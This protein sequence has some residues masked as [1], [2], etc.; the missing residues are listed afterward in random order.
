MRLKY[1][2]LSAALVAVSQVKVV[3]S[4]T[5]L[6]CAQTD[7]PAYTIAGKDSTCQIFIYSPGPKEGL[8]L[9]YLTEG[10]Q[11]L[12]VGQLCAS[13]Y[14]PWGS[15]KKMYNPFVVKATDGTW[16]ALWGVNSRSP[17]FAVAYSEDL[18]TW[19]PQDYPVVREKG[20]SEPVAYQMDDGT[21]DIYIKTTNG[22]RYVQASNDFRSF[23]EDSIEAVADDILWTR[24]SAMVDGKYYWGNEFEVSAFHL[25][26]IRNWFKALADDEA[27]NNR[28][29]PKTATD[30]EQLLTVASESSQNHL[31]TRGADGTILAKLNVKGSDTKRIS[32]KLVGIFFEDIS[33]AAD[34]GLCA[35]LLQNGDF[36]YNREDRE[37][38]WNDTTA[39][40]GVKTVSTEGGVSQNNPHYA[41][42]EVEPIINNGWD[43]IVVQRG[44]KVPGKDGKYQP[45]TYQVSLYARCLNC[46]QK[47]LTVALVGKK[48]TLFAQAKLKVRGSEWTEYK[49]QLVVTDKDGG[50]LSKFAIF[51]KGDGQVGI[52]LV[53]LK[54]Q[55]T[56][57]GH[58]LRKDLA[59]TIAALK[60][61]FVRFPG[62][63]MLHGQGLDNIYHWKE[64]IGPLKDRKPAY[65]IW[66]YHQTRQLGFYEYFQW[67]EDMGAEPL[68][69][70]AAGVPCQNSEANKDGIAGQQ[71][72]IP[73]AKMPQYIQDVLDLVEWAN[74][75][76]ATSKWAKM[77]ADAGHP[78][79]FHLKMIGIGNEDLISSVFRERYL[80]ICKALKEKYPNIEVVGTVGPFHWPSSDYIEGWK[81]ARENRMCIDAVDEHYYERPG[82]FINH[83]DYYDHYDRNQAKVYLGEYASRGKNATDNALAEGIHLCNVERNGDIVEMTSYAPLLSKDGYSNW[84]PDMIYFDNS[85][86]RVS[87]SYKIQKMF[88]VH[89]GDTYIASELD[90]PEE[91]RKYIGV[92]IVR[93]SRK[94]KTWLKIVNALP[95][96]LQIKL[97]G[98]YDG[99]VDVDARSPKVV[100]L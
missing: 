100:A 32:Q 61:K 65:N 14:G 62:G 57:K 36:E 96:K 76:P 71:D 18:V 97:S 73:M 30:L 46:K 44:A 77:R 29:L 98:L 86:V 34:G 27:Q 5:T 80:M 95:V 52:D 75:D 59:D 63:C 47:Q 83:Q 11:W 67:C 51:P 49:T 4:V 66:R 42:V 60:P 89:S 1:F 3:A 69:V 43:G 64:S 22:K 41:V 91:L 78:A 2:C 20:V 7:V 54:P 92:S 23:T 31:V 9:A 56:F 39:W 16:R 37:H 93:D 24:D 79:P 10:N 13:D 26:Y 38:Q 21:F 94:S 88:S 28:E 58:G 68:P 82:W 48:G 85:K 33:R 70:L 8:H 45:Y 17:Q 35:E 50:K 19:R 72:G 99:T 12:D 25:G 81:I 53:S 6:T 15:E 74:G 55:D 87:E 90:L 40:A 84:S